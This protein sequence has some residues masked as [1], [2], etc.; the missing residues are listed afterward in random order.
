MDKTPLNGK[1]SM[2]VKFEMSANS[3]MV[4]N[5]ASQRMSSVIKFILSA[6][7][8]EKNISIENNETYFENVRAFLFLE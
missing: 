7:D 6:N 2:H 4:Y 8:V 1:A 3:T 5:F